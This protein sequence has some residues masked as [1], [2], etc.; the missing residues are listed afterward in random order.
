MPIDR[1]RVVT[2]LARHGTAKYADALPD[3]RALFRGQMPEVA[4]EVVVSDNALPPGH[5]EALEP[6]VTLIGGSNDAWEF[7]AWDSAVGWLGDR[8]DGYDFVHL[9]TSAFRQLYVRYLDRFDTPMLRAIHGRAAAVGHVDYYND[10]VSLL[11]FGCQAWL[12]SSF[13]LL[14]PAELRLLGSLAGVTE[15]AAFF[16]GRPE[17]PFL[18]EAPISEGYRQNILGWLTGDGTGQGTGWHSRFRLDAGT[19]AFFESKTLAIL[20]EQML[21]SRLRAQGCALVDAT[22]LATQLGRGGGKAIG[23]IPDWRRQ[24]TSRDNDPAPPQGM[25]D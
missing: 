12:R 10:P 8:L 5:E 14:P 24:V 23:A 1:M 2:L 11:G 9:A 7:S 4:H 15:R 3:I 19:L 20:N 16:S 18:A 13:V 21:S 25:I 22:W 6:G 17:A